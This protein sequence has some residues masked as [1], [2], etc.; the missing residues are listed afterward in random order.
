MVDAIKTGQSCL[1]EGQLRLF[2]TTSVDRSNAGR[3]E[4]CMGGVWGTIAADSITTPWSE[5]NAQVACLQLGFSGALNAIFQRTYVLIEFP[6]ILLFIICSCM[7]RIPFTDQSSSPIHLS[8]VV[9]DGTEGNITSCHHSISTS[10]I[11]HGQDAFVVCR[12]QLGSSYSSCILSSN[13]K[14]CGYEVIL[15]SNMR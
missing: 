1:T 8:A 15:T 4:I 2:Q 9:C 6:C 11:G 7:Y 5:K 14:F 10:G 12:P 3:V 13:S